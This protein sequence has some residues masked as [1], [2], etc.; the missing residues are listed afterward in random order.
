MAPATLKIKIALLHR[1]DTI[2]ALADRWGCTRELLTKVI[3]CERGNPELRK[4]LARYV[5]VPVSQL[6]P[7]Q[8][9]QRGS[10]AA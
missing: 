3:H 1:G 9:N 7:P 4:K 10:K 8:A 2:Q 5:G 6:F